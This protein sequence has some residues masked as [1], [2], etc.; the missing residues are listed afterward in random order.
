MKPVQRAL[1]QPVAARIRP[2]GR[3]EILDNRI[4]QPDGKEKNAFDLLYRETGQDGDPKWASEDDLWNEY[5][6]EILK[7]WGKKSVN[8]RMALEEKIGKKN[9]TKLY[10]AKIYK[11]RPM[12]KSDEDAQALAD[13]DVRKYKYQVGWIGY[14]GKKWKT[15][16]QLGETHDDVR[17][18]YLEKHKIP[19]VDYGSPPQTNP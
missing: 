18:W 9:M 10:L 17:R 3:I 1:P 15:W 2:G 6:A 7:Y 19:F 14:T 4:R 16:D 12:P 11:H 5:E 8:R 13:N